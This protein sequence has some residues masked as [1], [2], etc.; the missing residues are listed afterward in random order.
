MFGPGRGACDLDWKGW[1]GDDPPY[2]APVFVLTHHERA[3]LEMKGGTPHFVT[4]GRD[5]A[6]DQARRRPANATSRSQAEPQ[7]STS[8]SPPA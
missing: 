2:H 4:D 8:T 3:S 1:W 6:L 5:A 7:L